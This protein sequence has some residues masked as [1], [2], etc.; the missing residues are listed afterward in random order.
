MRQESSS[1]EG[2][3]G[4]SLSSL[5]IRVRWPLPT[6]VPAARAARGRG[7]GPGTNGLSLTVKKETPAGEVLGV[8]LR[9]CCERP[10]VVL[11]PYR[12][13]DLRPR[14]DIMINPQPTNS[15]VPVSS[16]PSR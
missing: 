8:P 14:A 12:H 1:R 7:G 9:Y 3:I 16:T 6:S 4:F 15:A 10:Y 5:F 2:R 13:S 11:L